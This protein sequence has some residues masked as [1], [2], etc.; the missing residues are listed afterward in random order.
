MGKNQF[1]EYSVLMSVYANDHPDW[2]ETALQSMLDQTVPPTEFVI[3]EDG[4]LTEGLLRVLDIYTAKHPQ[5]IRR[6][7]LSECGGLGNAMRCGV[8]E[9]AC[10]WIARMDADDIAAAQRC[11]AELQ[12]AIDH[13][14]DIVGCDCEE[15]FESPEIRENRRLFPETHEELIRF[16]RRRTPFCHSAVM[17]KR[18]AVLDAGN[19]R[20]ERLLEDYD[21]FV[22]MF[23][24]GAVGYNV[25]RVLF[26]IRVSR[27]FFNRRSGWGYTN[28]LLKFNVRLLR[29]GW[30]RSGDF[31]VRSA[32]NILVGLAPGG[33]RELIYKKVLRK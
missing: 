28:R 26:Y 30:M 23:E 5:L 32:G 9:C 33:V 2:F 16:S 11:E 4:P 8:L 31:I 20:D 27:D 3:V 17:M 18:S 19:Y 25:K 12:A 22:R 10:D 24:N 1:P 13:N 7:A 15:F 21:L 6:V 14:A 29:R